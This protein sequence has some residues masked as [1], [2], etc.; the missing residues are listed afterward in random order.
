LPI[1]SNVEVLAITPVPRAPEWVS[2]ANAVNAAG[3]Y[4]DGTTFSSTGGIDGQGNAYSGDLLGLNQT[5]SSDTFRLGTPNYNN[6][7]K[8]AG[9]VIPLSSGQFSTLKMLATGVNGAQTSQTFTVTYSDNSTAQ[10]T[11]SL[12][13]WHTS[14]GYSGETAMYPMSYRD[15]YSGSKSSETFYL[16]GYAFSLNNGKIVKSITLPSNSNVAVVAMTLVP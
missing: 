14:S 11:Q 2:L 15:T 9:N 3:I 16:Y 5:W 10:F 8:A 1:D 12:S 13:D 6:V 7:V 4:I